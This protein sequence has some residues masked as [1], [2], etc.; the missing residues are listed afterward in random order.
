MPPG[1]KTKEFIMKYRLISLL[2]L[3][4][5]FI[6]SDAFAVNTTYDFKDPKG[7]NAISIQLNSMLEPNVGFATGIKGAV[8]IDQE[9]RKII[10]GQ[11]SVPADGVTMSNKTMTKVLH[12]KDW[13]NVKKYPDI[14]FK[15]IKIISIATLSA[16][17]YEVTV[18]GD[19]TLKGITKQIKA[20]ISI[21]F[22]P[23]KYKMRNSKGSGDLAA[24]KTSF[25]INRS[26]FKLKPEVPAEIVADVIE[27]NM[28]V[29]GSFKK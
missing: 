21:R 7:V 17:V 27:L 8:T 22:Y 25:Q 10:S 3:L 12:S 24:I 2:S 6:V 4:L 18:M 11:L 23:D 19:L 9:N 16:E 28:N 26:D 20:P 29:I 15:F 13:L 1:I 14:T 5:I